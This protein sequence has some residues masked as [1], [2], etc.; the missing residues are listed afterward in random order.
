MSSGHSIRQLAKWFE[1]NHVTLTKKL[2]D[3][4]RETSR[5]QV[6]TIK[7][8]FDALTQTVNLEEE[9]TR[10]RIRKT[11][12]EADLLLLKRRQEEKE[13]VQ[14]AE[15]IEL[16]LRPIKPIAGMVKDMPDRLASRCNPGDPAL[17]RGA[18]EKYARE[19]SKKIDQICK[20]SKKKKSLKP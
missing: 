3:M 19:I 17:A 4:G 11:R 9:L 12:E 2:K 10:E 5:G 1:V 13:V 18:L 7:E 15:A 16:S 8:A 6:F 20:P 14:L